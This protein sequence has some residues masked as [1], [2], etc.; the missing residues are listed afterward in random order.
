MRKWN[1][2][3]VGRWLALLVVPLVLLA[4]GCSQPTAT[5]PPTV[6]ISETPT[7]LPAPTSG[8]TPLPTQVPTPQPSPTRFVEEPTAP[9]TA[10]T[11]TSTPVPS[12]PVEDYVFAALEQAGVARYDGISWTLVIAGLP[13]ETTVYQLAVDPFT[14][15]T[16]L[17]ATSNGVYRTTDALGQCQWVRT[18]VSPTRSIAAHPWRQGEFYVGICAG[19][20]RF[21]KSTDG[22]V[23]WIPRVLPPSGSRSFDDCPSDIAVGA[24]SGDVLY[25]ANANNKSGHTFWKSTD[26][27]ESFALASN[28]IPPSGDDTYTTIA[29]DPD[30]D[31]L[32]YMSDEGGFGGD[33]IR[34]DDGGLSWA[35][36]RSWR[37]GAFPDVA[38]NPYEGSVWAAGLSNRNDG[39]TKVLLWSTDQGDSWTASP[40]LETK[41]YCIGM[42]APGVIWAGGDSGYVWLNTAGGVGDWEAFRVP[43]LPN[44]GYPWVNDI[45]PLS[46]YAT[47]R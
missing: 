35:Y 7:D 12:E 33:V 42:G 39:N 36:I 21:H 18:L 43:P 32:L 17:A 8:A 9:P 11:P 38:V 29:V 23:T 41:P 40:V 45:A 47:S 34:S 26:G 4:A 25:V 27:G 10:V 13:S 46:R 15:T 28:W 6:E 19:L 3:L 37:S 22:G 14:P 16:I 2:I 20:E 44:G 30:R 31:D 1:V 24:V 5:L